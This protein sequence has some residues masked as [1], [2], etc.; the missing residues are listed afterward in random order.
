MVAVDYSSVS[1]IFQHL[2][3]Y[4]TLGFYYWDQLG[5]VLHLCIHYLHPSLCWH[6]GLDSSLSWS[7]ILCIEKNVMSSPSLLIRYYECPLKMHCCKSKTTL[8]ISI[9]TL[10]FSVD[11]HCSTCYEW[12][13]Q[14][15]EGL[16]A[17]MPK[18]SGTVSEVYSINSSMSSS[19]MTSSWLAQC[20]LLHL[21]N[22]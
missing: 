6:T 13:L 9:R 14:S 3:L 2:T 22:F 8:Q 19:Q 17:D 21:I 1:L 12:C 7:T 5:F 16:Q 15:T 11:N 4:L 10:L 18:Y 20:S